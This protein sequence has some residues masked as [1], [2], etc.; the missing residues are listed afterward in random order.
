MR[1]NLIQS[2][3][4]GNTITAQQYNSDKAARDFDVKKELANRTFIKPL[5]SNG[6]L[7]KPS[8]FDMP[9]VVAKDLKYDWNA[10][11]HAVKG[12]A[13]DHELGRLNDSAMKLGG[14]TIAAY[15][16]TKKQTPMT[17]AFEFVGLCSFFGAMDLWPKLFLQLPAYLIHG[18]D[19]RQKYED[20]YGRKKLVFQDHQFIPWDLYS[21]DE[22]NKIG[23]RLGVP[24]NIPNRREFIQEKMRKI[25]LQ[26]NTMW[27]LTAGFA[28]PIMSAL[29]CNALEKPM[30][31]YLD[32]RN[33]RKA[34]DLLVNFT[35]EI[36]KYDFSKDH[37]ALVTLLDENLGK[38]IT[39]EL[40]DS[41]HSSITEGLD[42]VIATNLRKDLEQKLNSGGK[43]KISNETLDA[44]RGVLKESFGELS[45]TDK[46]LAQI[47]PDNDS[48]INAF[49]SKNL[50][51]VDTKDFSEHSKV[52]Q[53]LLDDR[54][55]K[56]I[57]EN[58]D[59]KT[60]KRL[61]FIMN[62]LVHSNEKGSDSALSKVFKL[63]PASILTEN[64][65]DSLKTVS[66]AINSLKA[67]N[68]VLD[69]YLYIKAAQ[70]PETILANSWNNTTDALLKV[71]KFTPEEIQQAR[72]D[73]E[74]AGE[75]LRNKMESIVAN[76]ETYGKFVAEVESLLAELH[77]RSSSVELQ[78]NVNSAD[79]GDK[80][81][82]RSLVNS[83]C[84]DAANI[85][86]NNGMVNAAEAIVGFDENA[87]TSLKGVLLNFGA[88]RVRGV[89]SSFYRILDLADLY[90]KVA[91]VEGLDDILDDKMPREVKEEAVELAKQTILEGHTSDFAVKFYQR[92]NLSP[93]MDDYSQIEA[94]D[95]KVI[96]KYFGT[97]APTD[98]AEM[99][100]D[101]NFFE[102]VMK[103]MFASELHPETYDKIKNSPILED[104]RN[105]RSKVLHFIGSDFYFAK[106][107]HLINSV[108][109]ENTPSEY[110]FA[111]MGCAPDEMFLNLF[112]N[113]FNSWKWFNIFGKLGAGLIG[114]TLL[115]Q[116]FMGH[117]K[118][119]EPIKEVK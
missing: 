17:K 101:K 89:K 10:F 111:L 115:S 66:S 65:I 7:L 112:N 69:R 29:I 38:S 30:A 77:G 18:F 118:K 83:S 85:L 90:Y 26:N 19:I 98:L 84:G 67:K 64:I 86:R 13:N 117:M 102:K 110:K 9:S 106:P 59:S 99:S 5:P 119:P 54:I 46:E 23:N 62:K 113:K 82:F 53:D 4:N 103:L 87:E 108:K 72:F 70:A 2:Y 44:V 39:P 8:L 45:L 33:N 78:P 41:I 79:G 11:R 40:I 97:H 91:H 43:Y 35:H 52:V 71:M 104:F 3:L 68:T 1:T 73:R 47:L 80:N 93:N 63:E 92:R 56:F 105:Y 22:I 76:K 51:G 34:E 58:P 116:F 81:L 55:A 96:N 94:K 107:N 32:Q 61:N 88:D 15:L 6:K 42:P 37:E 12:E 24:K 48:I 16:F 36:E 31:N 25:A 109:E 21:D 50:L 14:L 114:I 28:T 60:A 49:N 57:E 74:I 27:M 20:N 75:I 95:G 100:N